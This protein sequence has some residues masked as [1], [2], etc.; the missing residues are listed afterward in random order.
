MSA[1]HTTT[2][3]QCD[4]CD[5]SGTDTSSSSGGDC[6]DAVISSSSE[7]ATQT[8]ECL[9]ARAQKIE[10]YNGKIERLRNGSSQELRALTAILAQRREQQ[11]QRVEENKQFEMAR[12]RKIVAMEQQAVQCDMDKEVKVYGAFVLQRLQ[13]TRDRLYAHQQTLQTR[14]QQ[15]HQ[16]VQQMRFVSNGGDSQHPSSH[17]NHENGLQLRVPVPAVPDLLPVQTSETNN[18][19]NG[20]RG[21]TTATNA[22]KDDDTQTM[23]QPRRGRRPRR[24]VRLLLNKNKNSETDAQAQ[25]AAAV[26]VPLNMDEIDTQID[27]VFYTAMEHVRQ[28]RPKVNSHSTRQK[29]KL[30]DKYPDFA[31][32]K[33]GLSGRQIKDDM[34][35]M[36][37]AEMKMDATNNDTNTTSRKARCNV[38]IGCIS[39]PTGFLNDYVAVT[40]QLRGTVFVV[41]DA[42]AGAGG[43]G[44][45][46][47]Y[48]Y[49][50]RARSKAERTTTTTTTSTTR[51]AQQQQEMKDEEEEDVQTQNENENMLNACDVSVPQTC[52]LVEQHAEKKDDDD[53]DDDE[54]E[55]DDDDSDDEEYRVADGNDNT[56]TR[57]KNNDGDEDE[58]G[59]DVS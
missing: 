19:M 10:R 52:S 2:D 53:D 5:D 32:Y 42:V 3:C 9:S 51:T 45:G 24:R 7:S 36:L 29:H 57:A 58:D 28:C 14:L 18:D 41:G 49:Q 59:D 31:R 54:E 23:C 37:E 4:D 27:A 39:Q 44:A 47:G 38:Q 30:R 40:E 6:D 35:V 11:L 22:S 55:D 26:A 21:D 50:T 8:L 17:Q 15:Q 46:G 48:H 1:A 43:G 12:Y 16:Q 20:Q 25:A 13:H 33:F 56:A 34:Q